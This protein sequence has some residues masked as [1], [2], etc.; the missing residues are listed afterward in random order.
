MFPKS[1]LKLLEKFDFIQSDIDEKQIL[2]IHVLNK[3]VQSLN[4]PDIGVI[5]QEIDVKLLPNALF[6]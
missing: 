5:K 6:C 2:E 3:D 1:D 4:K